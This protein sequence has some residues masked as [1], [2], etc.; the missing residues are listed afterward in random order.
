MEQIL[1]IMGFIP[2]F[3]WF[4]LLL[5]SILVLVAN[6]LLNKIPGFYLYSVYIKIASILVLA[7]SVWFIGFNY[8]EN[9]HQEQIK[10]TK[11][12][13][14]LLE[15]KNKQLS[16]DLENKH[17]EK[18]QQLVEKTKNIIKFV[19]KQVFV[20]KEVVKYVESC[21]K[22]PNLILEAHNKAAE[23]EKQK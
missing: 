12:Q 2:N 22:L 16:T 5:L 23:L 7:I 17:Q 19:E 18:T 8:N 21:P 1:W 14:Q 20:D 11:H 3:V 4:A 6:K 9:K 13:I 15:E 10:Q